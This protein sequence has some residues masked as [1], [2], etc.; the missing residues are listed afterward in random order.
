MFTTARQGAPVGQLVATFEQLH[1]LGCI[2]TLADV[3]DD[4]KAAKE[5]GNRM[6]EMLMGV[7]N[8]NPCSGCPAYGGGSCAAF[9]ARFVG[10]SQHRAPSRPAPKPAAVRER[11]PK[12]KLKIRGENHDAHCTARN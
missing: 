10:P 2:Q 7:T 8:M 12:C 3:H 4:V 9:K 11:C 5:H 1:A 6:F